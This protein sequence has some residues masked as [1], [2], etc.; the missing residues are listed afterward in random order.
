MMLGIFSIIISVSNLSWGHGNR[1]TRG[2]AAWTMPNEGCMGHF[3]LCISL[4][5]CFF[6]GCTVHP[7]MGPGGAGLHLD[8]QQGSPSSASR[9]S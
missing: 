6:L 3:M 1:K 7:D 2:R 5:L 9:H 8:W 4:E